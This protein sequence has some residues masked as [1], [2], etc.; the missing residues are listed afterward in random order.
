MNQLE[1]NRPYLLC[2]SETLHID[3]ALLCWRWKSWSVRKSR[4]PAAQSVWRLW[5][6]CWQARSMMRWFRLMS[7]VS[8]WPWQCLRWVEMVV[9]AV[10][11]LRKFHSSRPG[12][13]DRS[14]RIEREGARQGAGKAG[15][16]WQKQLINL[17]PKSLHSDR[18][19]YSCV[20]WKPSIGNGDTEWYPISRHLTA[21]VF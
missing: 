10:W 3:I 18:C 5:M 14:R 20:L 1:M 16:G 4:Q 15:K 19:D 12:K 6:P 17:L 9:R 7:K 13:A 11:V 21:F 8:N 2:I